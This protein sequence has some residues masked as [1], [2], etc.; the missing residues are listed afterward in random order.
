MPKEVLSVRIDQS[1]I[2]LLKQLAE[3]HVRTVAS[4]V[5]YL[6]RCAAEAENAKQDKVTE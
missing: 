5:A 6:I 3:K 4:E 2:D 1:D